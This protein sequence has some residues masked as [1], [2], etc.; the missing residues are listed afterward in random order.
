MS[1][2]RQAMSA[3]EAGN[4]AGAMRVLRTGAVR[5]RGSSHDPRR[6]IAKRWSM[7]LAVVGWPLAAAITCPVI[8]PEAYEQRNA[9]TAA[10]S[11]GCPMR[12]S[13]EA[14]ATT[15]RASGGKPVAAI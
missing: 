11:C 2:F 3:Y 8:H 7:V 9:T 1:H 4:L 5:G 15:A 14:A 12:P 6:A 10:M 13:G